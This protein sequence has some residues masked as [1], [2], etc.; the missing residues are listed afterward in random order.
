MFVLP[1]DKMTVEEKLLAMEMIWEDLSRNAE[2]IPIPS[3][4]KELL[5]ARERDI[6]EGRAKFIPW[7]EARRMIEEETNQKRGS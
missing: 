3:W 4:H 2:D 6:Q 7:E 5:E 1:L